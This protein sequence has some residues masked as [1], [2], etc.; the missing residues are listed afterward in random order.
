MTETD[1]VVEQVREH[2]YPADEAQPAHDL[3]RDCWCCPEPDHVES[4]DAWFTGQEI[5]VWR[6]K[7]LQ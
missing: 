2:I 3:T 5:E 6:H 1:Q 4:D 7:F